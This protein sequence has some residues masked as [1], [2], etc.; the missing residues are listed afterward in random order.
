MIVRIPVGQPLSTY[1]VLATPHSDTPM[2]LSRTTFADLRWSAMSG[3]SNTGVPL[4][5]WLA[6]L[7]DAGLIR[8][9]TRP[10][11]AQPPPTSIAALAARATAR[12]SVKAA[13]DELDFL[14]LGVLDAL[15]VL[16]ADTTPVPVAKLV[17]LL[18]NRTSEKQ[19]LAT[20]RTT[21][22][23]AGV[24]RRQGAGS[25]RSRFGTAP[26]MRA[27]RRWRN[28]SPGI[29]RPPS[30]VWTARSGI[31]WS[32]CEWVRRSA[33]P[34]MPPRAPSDRPVPGFAAGL[35][36]QIDDETVILPR[37][38]A[39][40]LR[41]DEPGPVSLTAPDPVV[42][43]S[44]AKVVDAS[45]AGAV[46][47]LLREIDVILELLSTTPVPEL[48]TGGLGCVRRGGSRS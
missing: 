21:G 11:L 44:A 9:G 34:A 19:V 1:L 31:C 14:Q 15:L 18:G 47:D 40:A 38:V 17:G 33:A 12:Q 42:R 4:G 22:T 41:G 23:R 35:L 27:R 28:R 37:H 8:L 36:R 32:G 46:I 16:Q 26:G 6:D 25:R 13:G 10:D 48:R 45:A 20:R 3:E 24:G 5:A 2:A 29:S 7:S 30:K 43:T 39:Q